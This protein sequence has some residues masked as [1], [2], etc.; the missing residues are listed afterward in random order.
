MSGVTRP[1][2][3]L[4]MSQ[5]SVV[6]YDRAAEQIASLYESTTFEAVHL[7]ALDVLPPAG[8]AVL[9]VGAGSGRDAA[10]LAARGYIVTAVEPSEGLRREALRRHVA[11]QVSWMDDALPHLVKLGRQQFAFILVSAVWM[12]IAPQDRPTA[13]R[14]L[15]ELLSSDGH[16][17]LSLRFGPDDPKRW[18]S[19]VDVPTVETDALNA[20]LTVVRRIDA[21][22]VLGRDV[23]SWATLVLAKV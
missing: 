1:R 19:R 10:A 5:R 13:M 8:S 3:R 17:L 16:I 6:V 14:R 21:K 9:D 18:I 4:P 15:S 7:G 23:V 2:S 12:H 22:D 20:G 11:S